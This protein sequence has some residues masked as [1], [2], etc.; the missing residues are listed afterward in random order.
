MEEFVLFILSTFALIFVVLGINKAEKTEHALRE[1]RWNNIDLRDYLDNA[2]QRATDFARK[3]KKLE[4][5]ILDG[6]KANEYDT[7]I[8]SKIKKELFTDANQEK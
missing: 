3:I 4:D 2:E 6:N 8:L 5:I 1:E 7:I